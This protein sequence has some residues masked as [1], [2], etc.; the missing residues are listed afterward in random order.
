MIWAA[1]TRLMLHLL[2]LLYLRSSLVKF[3]TELDF[4]YIQ[5]KKEEQG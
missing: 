3:Y 5:V 2:F 4:R 1:P